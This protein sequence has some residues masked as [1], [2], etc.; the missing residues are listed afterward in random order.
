MTI[1]IVSGNRGTAGHKSSGT[2]LTLTPSAALAV[3][4]YGLLAVVVDNVGTAEGET[5]DVSVTDTNGNTWIKLREQT[6]ANTAALS[7]VTCALFL[8]ELNAELNGTDTVTIALTANA[9]AKGAGLAELSSTDPLVLSTGGANG[10]NEVAGT[11]YSVALSGL[12]SVAG[13]Y[14]G[15]TAAENE[16]GV[17]LDT[18][19]TELAFAEIG[20]GTAGGSATNVI[21]HVG[22]LANTSTGDTFDATVAGSDRATILVRLEEVAAGGPQT[23]DGVLFTKAP[24]FP[25]G[26]LDLRL[27]GATFTK[28]ATFPTGQINFTVSGTTFQKAPT[29]PTGTLI[30][31]QFLTGTTF[32][33]APT[34]PTGAISSTGGTQT[35]SG[36]LFVKAPS[37]PQGRLDLNLAGVTFTKA[38]SFPQGQLNLQLAG[39]TFVQAPTFPAG[40]LVQEQFLTGAT[41]QQ[42]PTFPT[43]SISAGAA[44]Q[45][46]SGVLFV[47]APSFPTGK[48]NLQLTGIT[49][50]KAGTF[51]T[52]ALVQEQTLSGTTFVKAPTFPQG[53]LAGTQILTGVLFT[54]AGTFPVGI[55]VQGTLG[56][57]VVGALA[58][59][60]TGARQAEL[61]GAAS[62]EFDGATSAE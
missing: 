32:T 31:A 2:S 16:T 12:T 44:T 62:A 29:F 54:K 60:E 55:V 36:T 5:D 8:A 26:R 25:T 13:L 48:L 45:N 22:T 40:T 9:T 42:V 30:Q 23:L 17:V 41:F 35:L 10:T 1:A 33:K 20:S 52:G 15:M 37:F 28:A 50:T 14:V 18:A 56:G 34:F 53:A 38:P 59:F 46:L 57:P 21:A 6:E 51:L 24:T 49:F 43:G 47:T 3:G 4:N 19:Y 58:S 27:S 11:S 7:G 39:T 61:A